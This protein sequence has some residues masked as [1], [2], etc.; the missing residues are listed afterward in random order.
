MNPLSEYLVSGKLYPIKDFDVH[1]LKFKYSL[2]LT[3]TDRRLLITERQYN[4]LFC[5][6]FKKVNADGSRV[7]EH[8]NILE[9]ELKGVTYRLTISLITNGTLFCNGYEI[10]HI[11]HVYGMVKFKKTK[12]GYSKEI[13]GTVYPY[14]CKVIKSQ[15]NEQ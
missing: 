9:F 15:D 7:Y 5:W 6:D 2:L 13:L 4:N 14:Q 8:S 1:T 12:L 11:G 3:G 10:H